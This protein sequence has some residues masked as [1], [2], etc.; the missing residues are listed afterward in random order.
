MAG[1]VRVRGATDEALPDLKGTWKGTIA[2]T[3]V[4]PATGRGVPPIEA[5]YVVRQAGSRLRIR[6]ATAGA[7]SEL[8]AGRLFRDGDGTPTVTGV[9]RNAPGP[10]QGGGSPVHHGA[11]LVRA[12]GGRLEGTYWTDRGTSGT[13]RFD[14]WHEGFARDFGEAAAGRYGRR[15][16]G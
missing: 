5:Y 10:G 3:W 14:R 16:A 13:L 15:K 4:D 1:K 8:L 7:T 6:L 2:S 11:I 9:Y 12:D